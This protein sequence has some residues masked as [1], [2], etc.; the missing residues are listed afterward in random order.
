MYYPAG[1]QTRHGPPVKQDNERRTQD[2]N[3]LTETERRRHLRGKRRLSRIVN[4]LHA[5][6]YPTSWNV[7]GA[8][9]GVEALRFRCPCC[10][11][12]ALNIRIGCVCNQ[13]GIEI[14]V[15]FVNMMESAPLAGRTRRLCEFVDT[16]HIDGVKFHLRW[17]QTC[18]QGA[19]WRLW[20]CTSLP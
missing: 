10:S 8:V 18:A 19:V 2:K 3:I 15:F 14:H 9:G 20:R 16:V 12:N 7:R 5:T 13:A 4:R 11:Q 17:Q 6:Q 1:L